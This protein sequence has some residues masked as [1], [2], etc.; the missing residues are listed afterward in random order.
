MQKKPRLNREK[1]H[2]TTPMSAA[3]VLVLRG[4]N[5]GGTNQSRL[6]KAAWPKGKKLTKPVNCSNSW[7]IPEK[8]QKN[9]YIQPRPDQSMACEGTVAG[10]AESMSFPLSANGSLQVA[11]GRADDQH[12]ATC[13][14]IASPMRIG[15]SGT[16]SVVKRSTFF[17]NSMTTVDPSRKRPISWPL[18]SR[19]C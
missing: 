5:S 7:V 14:P 12:G 17:G 15:R 6:M 13:W 19:I 1:N 10:L 16:Q 18:W 8:Y 4:N 3:M 9:R 2:S 11:A